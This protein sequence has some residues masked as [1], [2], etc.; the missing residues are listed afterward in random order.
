MAN[1]LTLI[2]NVGS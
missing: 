1:H 2:V